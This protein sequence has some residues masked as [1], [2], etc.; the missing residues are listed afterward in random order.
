MC[1]RLRLIFFFL[2]LVS[3]ATQAQQPGVKAHTAIDPNATRAQFHFPGNV[4]ITMAD[5]HHKLI[6]EIQAGE[7]IRCVKGGKVTT[8]CIQ[9][10]ESIQ[11]SG[12]WLTALYLKPVDELAFSRDTW[13]LVPALLLETAPTLTVTTPEGPK[14]VSQLKKGDVLYRYEPTTQ[15][16]STW[17]VGIV[18]RKARR[19]NTMYALV[20]DEGAYLLENM[21]ASEK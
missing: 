20:T 21:V 14:T 16:V 17:K 7:P 4:T 11:N 18:Q 9:K 5:G 2:F 6:S 19:V 1:K 13:P 12:T 8:D 10:V 15:Q 3:V